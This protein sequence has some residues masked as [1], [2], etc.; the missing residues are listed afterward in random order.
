MIAAAFGYLT[1]VAGALT[2]E[3]IDV[4]VILNALRAL[5]PAW[6][7]GRTSLQP[8]A[9]RALR[10]DHQALEVSLDRLREIA[11]GLDDATPAQAV[12]LI[13][14]A[15]ALVTRRVVADARRT[16]SGSGAPAAP[17]EFAAT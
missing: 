9:V 11:D 16:K 2:Q 4:A 5:T 7:P 3:A 8:S 12:S 6:Q 13:A 1:P 14:E 10:R 17:E 15:S